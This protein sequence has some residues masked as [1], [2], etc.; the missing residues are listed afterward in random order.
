MNLKYK[1]IYKKKILLKGKKIYLKTL[2]CKDY[3]LR[4]KNWLNDKEI[5]KYLEIRHYSHNKRNIIKFIEL[6]FSLYLI[7]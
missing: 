5:N 4:Y 1:S 2:E 7:L 3:S 6:V